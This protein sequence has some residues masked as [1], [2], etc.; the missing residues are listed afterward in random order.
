MKLLPARDI[1]NT[2]LE[3]VRY[4]LVTLSVVF[5]LN[6][7]AP[8]TYSAAPTLVQDFGSTAAN[9]SGVSAAVSFSLTGLS[10][11]PILSIGSLDFKSGLLSC[12]GGFTVCSA[13]VTFLPKSVGLKQDALILKNLSGKLIASAFL[14][15]IGTGPALHAFPATIGTLA[16]SGVWGYADGTASTASFRNP[17][18]AAVDLQGNLYVADS[19]NMVIRKIAVG[20]A[21]VS[22]VAGNGSSGNAGDNGVATSARLNTPTG[23]AVD[24]AGNLFI[25]DQQNGLIRRVDAVTKLITTVAGGGSS[26]ANGVAATTALL[27][28]PDDV[29]VDSADNLYIADSFHGLVRQVNAASGIINTIAGGGGSSGTDGVGDGAAATAAHL[30]NPNGLALDSVGN[31]FIADTGDSLIRRVDASSRIMTA[32]AGNGLSGNRGD[33]GPATSAELGSPMGI[34]VDAA[35]DLY[36]ADFA[37]NTIRMVNAASGIIST[38]AGSGTAAYSGNGGVATVGTLSSPTDVVL[39]TAGNLL[40]VDNGNN[41][42]RK[43]AFQPPA[44]TFP[45]TNVSVT[46]A[47]IDFQMQNFGNADLAFSSLSLSLPFHEEPSGGRDCS[48]ASVL[49]AGVA[50]QVDTAFI[51]TANISFTGMLSA[52]SNSNNQASATF[53]ASLA[54]VGL[55]GT[56]AG[57]VTPTSLAFATTG[58]GNHSVAQIVTLKNTGT[59]TLSYISVVTVGAN[60]LDFPMTSNCTASLVVNAT[61]SI[62]VS[63]APA[64]SG[65]RTAT[66][67]I[68]NNATNSPQ[69]VGLTG[70]GSGGPLPVLSP[71]ALS[72]GTQLISTA[73]AGASVTLSNQGAGA[74]SLYGISIAGANAADFNLMGSTCPGSLGVSASCTV[75]V[76]FLPIGSGARTATLLIGDSAGNSP[77]TLILSGNGA[78]ISPPTLSTTALSFASQPKF[79]VARPQSITITSTSGVALGISGMSVTGPNSPDFSIDQSTCGSVLGA[80]ASCAIT[81]GFVPSDLG[82]RTATLEFLYASGDVRTLTLSGTGG[83]PVVMPSTQLSAFFDPAANTPRINYIG[84]DSHVHQ[85]WISSAA[86]W[87]DFDA[88]RTAGGS[89][90][91][92]SSSVSGF[93]NPV[94]NN[95]EMSYIGTDSH[96][97]RLYVAGGAWRD[98]DLTA[99]TGSLNAA[100][101]TPISG[102]FD[103]TYNTARISYVAADAHIHQFWM[104]GAG[105]WRDFDATAATGAPNPSAETYLSSFFDPLSKT[106]RISY[107]SADSHLHHFW[108]NGASVW[109]DFDATASLGAPLV[110]SGSSVSGYF[111]PVLNTPVIAYEGV[112]LHVH[113]ISVASGGWTDFDLTA[114]AASLNAAASA[115][116]SGVFDTATNTPRVSYLG[117]DMHYHHFWVNGSGAWKDFDTTAATNSPNAAVGAPLSSFFDAASNTVRINFV[118][119]NDHIDQFWIRN[120]QLWKNFDATAAVRSLNPAL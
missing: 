95:S 64:L 94:Q 34:R 113:Q 38:I 1:Q 102:V 71:S 55:A 96:I 98:A 76:N 53:T 92:P 100:A 42:I 109:K 104:N 21:T 89:L 105:A 20:S 65:S 69:L 78:D 111:N 82:T 33:G 115:S 12:N 10:A 3:R 120:G 70:A 31:L 50:C 35:G 18:G 63:F 67:N 81:I 7:S 28:G 15:G 6:V 25:A 59:A 26:L 74:L 22:T 99:V 39:D 49:A 83:T 108:V 46:S 77:Q 97:H 79:S 54:G 30:N 116:I 73:S 101:R 68:F 5:G 106:P 32:V 13:T 11:M 48:A 93:F 72:F 107:I 114:A 45:S 37:K 103:V 84:A 2:G 88:T 58:V 14:H 9:G 91:R 51:P 40:I 80:G 41:V 17:Q 19:I 52:T 44:T 47:L 16:G 90:V 85:F 24:A 29:V 61:C 27:S 23:V 4:L 112:D 57:T 119:S 75:S 8:L 66:L 62:S 60:S 56:P 118:D 117:S 110:A 87:K 36:I 86:G 43:L